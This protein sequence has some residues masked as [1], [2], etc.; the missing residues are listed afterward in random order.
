MKFVKHAQTELSSRVKKVLFKEK[1]EILNAAAVSR[2]L[3][4]QLFNIVP[5]AAQAE[6]AAP[7]GGS[8]M[9]SAAQTEQA[10]KEGTETSWRQSRKGWAIEGF[11][12]PRPPETPL[13]RIDLP[14]DLLME[15]PNVIAATCFADR[16]AE[17]V[18]RS[19]VDGLC[20]LRA[21]SGFPHGCT[22]F[23][24]S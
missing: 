17:E 1:E 7:K 20:G 22:D 2:V 19:E 21:Y 11:R 4:D 9:P 15:V 8:N 23:P 16:K 10:S 13:L 5:S 12:T 24:T 6:Q 3:Y 18:P 14:V